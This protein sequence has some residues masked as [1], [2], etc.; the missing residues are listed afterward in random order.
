VPEF[1][2][3]IQQNHGATGTAY[4]SGNPCI[5]VKRGDGW[6][7]NHLPGSELEKINPALRWA[8]SLPVRSEARSAVVGVINVDGLDNLPTVLQHAD[9]QECQAVVVA[10]LSVMQERI[11]P[12]LEAAFRG[13]EPEPLEG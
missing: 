1:D 3:E 12:C 7:G 11:Q 5:L 10:L 2:L 9:T 6:S 4:G 13:E 8:I